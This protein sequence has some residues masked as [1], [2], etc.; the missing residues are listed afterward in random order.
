MT[1]RSWPRLRAVNSSV[2]WQNSPSLAVTGGWPSTSRVISAQTCLCCGQGRWLAFLSRRTSSMMSSALR[3][4]GSMLYTAP[5]QAIC[6]LLAF[7]R[8]VRRRWGL[9]PSSGSGR[10]IGTPLPSAVTTIRGPSSYTSP[11]MLSG[12]LGV[13]PSIS[14]Q[15]AQG[16]TD[17]IS[18]FVYQRGFENLGGL[19]R[20]DPFLY[21]STAASR[22]AIAWRWGW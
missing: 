8:L 4:N 19:Q 18:G 21:V 10:R 6:F 17:N 3:T 14:P 1:G 5:T 12:L 20:L 22:A 16:K 9:G 11:L 15:K 13:D 2:N 7:S